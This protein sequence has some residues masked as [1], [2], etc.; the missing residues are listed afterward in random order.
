MPGAANKFGS[1]RRFRSLSLPRLRG[2]LPA[3]LRVGRASEWPPSERLSPGR[4]VRGERRSQRLPHA[5]GVANWPARR[6]AE[7]FAAL[8]GA[9]ARGRHAK[10]RRDET[11]REEARQ[12]RM[13]RKKWRSIFMLAPLR[14]PACM[15]LPDDEADEIG[16]TMGSLRAASCA[17]TGASR[18]VWRLA[19]SSHQSGCH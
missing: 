7:L 10:T 16:H 5:A 18:A 1:R 9:A 19:R 3:P 14:L 11:R 12:E 6:R 15:T 13:G 2:R 4:Q 8:L 17:K